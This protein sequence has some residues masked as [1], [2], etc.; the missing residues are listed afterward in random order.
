[1]YP[2]NSAR[3]ATW[4]P[5]RWPDLTG[6]GR[7]DLVIDHDQENAI[8]V[9]LQTS[10]GTLGLET[11]YPAITYGDTPAAGDLNGDGQPDMAFTAGPGEIGIL[12]G[13]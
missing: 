9:M 6:N 1:V 5:T 3:P 10:R 11:L 12:Y 4:S 2:G 8:G 7:N 13:K